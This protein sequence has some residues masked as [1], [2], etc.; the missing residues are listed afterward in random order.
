MKNLTEQ[1]QALVS[2]ITHSIADDDNWKIFG[3][4]SRP[5]RGKIFNHF[6][7][8]SL[9][10]REQFVAREIALLSIID[11]IES[12]KKTDI[13]DDNKLVL[14]FGAFSIITYSF[15]QFWIIQE[16]P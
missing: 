11:V 13:S 16:Q 10:E 9:L 2:M 7:D 14:V 1:A 4:K 12:I 3:F 8:K 5:V 6:I 15:F